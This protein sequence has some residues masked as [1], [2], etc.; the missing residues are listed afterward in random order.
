MMRLVLFIFLLLGL[1][2]CN[3]SAAKSLEEC[4]SLYRGL[5]NDKSL[6]TP[7]LQ[8]EFLEKQGQACMGYDEFN[9]WVVSL[10]QDAGEYDKSVVIAK[11][12]LGAAKEYKPNL[13]QFIAE[14]ELQKGNEIEAIKQGE[15]IAQ[16]FPNY[17][18]ILGFLGEIAWKKQD[19][20]RAL[21]LSEK[22][23]KIDKSALALLGI[24]TALHQLD[25]H[26]E[27]VD[28]VYKALELEPDRIKSATGIL[29][30]VASLA[31]LGRKEEAVKLAQRH[32][33]ADPN[34][35][36]N[37]GF[38]DLIAKIGMNPV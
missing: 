32:I 18:P 19:W 36:S 5:E 15:Q 21:E 31:I 9:V 35:R 37:T 29:E 10:Y 14:A 28:A 12:A 3:M 38:V 34:W 26:E 11:K 1:Y 7:L 33:D 27:V 2:G 13:Q 23:Y 22:E 17:V 30:G 25:R 4:A 8:A 6:S 20:P 24:A 16:E